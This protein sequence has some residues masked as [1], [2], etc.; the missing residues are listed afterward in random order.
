[1]GTWAVG[2]AS[3][4]GTRPSVFYLFRFFKPTVQS[5]VPKNK[6]IRLSFVEIF[7]LKSF[8]AFIMAQN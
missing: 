2:A 1:M 8:E 6:T 4:L 7:R 3:Y 5:L